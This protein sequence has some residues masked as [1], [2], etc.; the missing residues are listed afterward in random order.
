MGT[1]LLLDAA[2][3]LHSEKEGT[4]GQSAYLSTS[5]LPVIETERFTTFCE[6]Y[7]RAATP[8]FRWNL[9]V[10]GV[11]ATGAVHGWK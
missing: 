4:T 3:A 11:I 6:P 5:H 1:V 10:Y 9:R 8:S 2:P 7:N